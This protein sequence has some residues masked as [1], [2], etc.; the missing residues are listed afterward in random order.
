MVLP[1]RLRVFPHRGQAFTRSQVPSPAWR[2]CRFHTVCHGPNTGG[3]SRHGT[4][5]RN[6]YNI[7][8]TTRRLFWKFGPRFCSELGFSQTR[9]GRRGDHLRSRRPPR[10]RLPFMALR[11]AR[12][13][14][15]NPPDTRS[16]KPNRQRAHPIPSRPAGAAAIPRCGNA[17]TSPTTASANSPRKTNGS[18]ANSSKPPVDFAP[19]AGEKRH[20]ASQLGWNYPAAM[21]NPAARRQLSPTL[22]SRSQPLNWVD[23]VVG[24]TRSGCRC[25]SGSRDT[26]PAPLLSPVGYFPVSAHM[27]NWVSS[28]ASSAWALALE[29]RNQFG[30]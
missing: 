29:G 11:P 23:S 6:R 3:R 28:S 4:L 30:T 21:L 24:G 18:D 12:H 5:V 16:N 19:T 27:T 17:S 13:Q 15:R 14:R 9:P 7:P 26:G 25:P 2:G 10:R 8:S 22:R 1:I 20:P